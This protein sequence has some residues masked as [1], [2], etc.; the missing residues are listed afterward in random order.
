MDII[1]KTRRLQLYFL[2]TNTIIH[3]GFRIT[4]TE[5]ETHTLKGHVKREKEL[6][7]LNKG[8]HDI[9]FKHEDL[10]NYINISKMYNF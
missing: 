10:E 2:F 3:I 6:I 5:K 1:S 7:V 4:I 8:S 9:F